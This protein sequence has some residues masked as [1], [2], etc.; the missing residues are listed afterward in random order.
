M[1]RRPHL[2]TLT[3]T[4]LVPTMAGR[5]LRASVAAVAIG[6]ALLQAAPA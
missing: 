6:M 2:S 4:P 3:P 5:W 1:R